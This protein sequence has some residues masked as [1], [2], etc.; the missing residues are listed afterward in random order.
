MNA[1]L[2]G[3]RALMFASFATAF[4]VGAAAAQTIAPGQTVNGQ[5]TASDARSEGGQHQDVY[6]L[7]GRAG[8]V[9]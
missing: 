2:Q 6:T 7:R 9:L 3:V 5:L 1:M 4:M 8:Q